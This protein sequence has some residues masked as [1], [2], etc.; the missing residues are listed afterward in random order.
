MNKI[1]YDT[2]LV[3]VVHLELLVREK[4]TNHMNVNVIK[5]EGLGAKR[6]CVSDNFKILIFYHLICWY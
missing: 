4:S 2:F 1:K 3:E 6:A 5:I